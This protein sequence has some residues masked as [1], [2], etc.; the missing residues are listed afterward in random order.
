VDEIGDIADCS[1]INMKRHFNSADQSKP[2]RSKGQKTTAKTSSTDLGFTKKVKPTFAIKSSPGKTVKSEPDRG[3]K[4]NKIKGHRIKSLSDSG[5]NEENKDKKINKNV[6]KEKKV[7]NTKRETNLGIKR[8]QSVKSLDK[9]GKKTTFEK[10]V[11]NK[12]NS[13]LKKTKKGKFQE[14]SSTLIGKDGKPQWTKVKE[15]KKKLRETRKVHRTGEEQY[16]L[17][18]K[19]KALWEKLRVRAHPAPKREA[20]VSELFILLK[21]QIP[22][23]VYS[24]DMARVVQWMLK[25]GSASVRSAICEELS[26]HSVRCLQSQYANFC[27]RRQIKMLIRK[28]KCKIQKEKLIL[29]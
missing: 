25:L 13:I 11:G 9:K 21:G 17:S 19:A 8:E 6:N 22:Q 24:H 26:V 7:Q 3:S 10:K 20:L 14:L 5:E 28:K 12:K 16:Q 4:F 23:V 15:E 2:K 29:E 18:V 1:L 27:V